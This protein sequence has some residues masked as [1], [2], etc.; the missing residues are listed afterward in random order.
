MA[1]LHAAT[2]LAA[3]L[4]LFPAFAGTL[5][6]LFPARRSVEEMYRATS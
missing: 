3:A 6:S 2:G 5:R 4:V 1:A